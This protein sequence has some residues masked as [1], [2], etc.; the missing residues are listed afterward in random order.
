MRSLVAKDTMSHIPGRGT[1]CR[2]HYG[3]DA[4]FEMFGRFVQASKETFSR[5]YT[6]YGQRGSC[7]RIDLRHCTT[8]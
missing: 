2:D 1:A 3:R 5:N 6:M 4:V 8:W 7:G